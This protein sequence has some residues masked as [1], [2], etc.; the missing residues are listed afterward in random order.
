MGMVL[1][2]MLFCGWEQ[3]FF[4]YILDVRRKNADVRDRDLPPTWHPSDLLI[5]IQYTV[6]SLFFFVV[7]HGPSVLFFP[8]VPVQ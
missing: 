5:I 7:L 8:V 1:E 6:F 4:F 2:V 3:L